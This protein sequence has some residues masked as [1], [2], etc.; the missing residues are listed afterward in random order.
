MSTFLCGK[1]PIFIYHN[2]IPAFITMQNSI[3]ENS[4]KR[5]IGMIIV[6]HPYSGKIK[7][8]LFHPTA[9]KI[10]RELLL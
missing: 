10:R 6:K 8:K 9:R 3:T 5:H 7:I 2:K 4:A 1:M